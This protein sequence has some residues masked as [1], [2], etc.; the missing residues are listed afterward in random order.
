[1]F[2][3]LQDRLFQAQLAASG[4]NGHLI[5]HVES[6]QVANTQKHLIT[7]PHLVNK[8]KICLKVAFFLFF[9]RYLN[10]TSRA[11]PVHV[12]QPAVGVAQ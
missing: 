5:L 4:N 1:M 12:D 3:C 6:H 11:V 9:K 2:V 8:W 10:S 7:G